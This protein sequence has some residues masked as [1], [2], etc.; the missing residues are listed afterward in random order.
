MQLDLS[1][2]CVPP[3]TLFTSEVYVRKEY[4]YYQISNKGN[5]YSAEVGRNWTGYLEE[6]FNI[7]ETGFQF[8]R[9][10]VQ[11]PHG[12]MILRVRPQVMC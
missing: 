1:E 2:R 9:L 8:T 6:Y 12:V 3:Q 11:E 4:M 7:I 5:N 10:A